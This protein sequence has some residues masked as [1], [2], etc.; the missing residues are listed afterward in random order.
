MFFPY[1]FANGISQ[2]IRSHPT[3]HHKNFMS[4]ELKISSDF[5]EAKMWKRK[6]KEN[7]NRMRIEWKEISSI[8]LG[9]F[10]PNNTMHV[11]HQKLSQKAEK[12]KVSLGAHYHCEFFGRLFLFQLLYENE[13][14]SCFKTTA[15]QDETPISH[16]N[17]TRMCSSYMCVDTQIRNSMK[18]GLTKK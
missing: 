3:Q 6:W 7:A 16:R 14:F 10:S 12:L 9:I 4:Q 15:P 17:H 1:S 11:Y 13:K 8:F 5:E 18:R 2:G